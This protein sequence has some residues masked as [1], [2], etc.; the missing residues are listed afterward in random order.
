MI[1]FIMLVDRLLGAHP[2]I[3]IGIALDLFQ[4]F[5][6]LAGDDAVDPFASR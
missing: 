6:G 1:R 2:V 5:A 3:A 4:R